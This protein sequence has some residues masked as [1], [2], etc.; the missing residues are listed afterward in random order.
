MKKEYT[1][2]ELN[3]EVQSI[4]GYYVL[5][6]EK[7]LKHN[8]RDVL[9]LIGHGVVD[10]SCCGIGGCRYALVPGYIT[11]WKNRKDDAGK[12][13]TEVEPIPDDE[14]KSEILDMIKKD[15]MVNQIQFY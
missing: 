12:P 10:S 3:K 5:E 11:G 15:E 4:S 1:H 7:V 13:V 6:E 2:V 8:G 14:S 9:Y